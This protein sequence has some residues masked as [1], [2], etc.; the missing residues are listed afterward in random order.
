MKKMP[1]KWKAYKTIVLFLVGY[2]AYIAIEVTFRGF[3]YPLMGVCSGI[4]IVLLDKINDN[5]SWDVD[6]LL[7]GVCGSAL[8]TLFELIIGEIHLH[9]GLLPAMWDYSN[10]P[11]NYHGIIC[12][13]FSLLWVALSILAIFLADAINYYVFETISEPPY[14][15]IFG[16]IVLVFK[17]KDKGAH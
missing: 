15:R 1:R 17:R 14:Y 2:C 10:V 3:S 13:P 9:T 6:L 16:H 12:L 8:I 4:A 11:L 5:I 7:Q